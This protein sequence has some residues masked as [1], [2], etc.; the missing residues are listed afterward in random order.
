MEELE[1]VK[2]IIGT[3]IG[4][5]AKYSLPDDEDDRT[6]FEGLETLQLIS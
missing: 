5:M 3:K 6:A 1:W 2:P 4:R